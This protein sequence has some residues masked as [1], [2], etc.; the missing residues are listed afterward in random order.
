MGN[1][2]IRLHLVDE[3]LV[4]RLLFH[5]AGMMETWWEQFEMQSMILGLM[6]NLC[7]LFELTGYR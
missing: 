4:P 2:V 6:A 5:S 1:V 7:P 3:R